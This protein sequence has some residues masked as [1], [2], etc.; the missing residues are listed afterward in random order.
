MRYRIS[1]ISTQHSGNVHIQEYSCLS[2]TTS[3][4][5]PA[6]SLSVDVTIE[7]LEPGQDMLR[8]LSDFED[9]L[10]GSEKIHP[11]APS[12]EELLRLHAPEFLL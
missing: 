8:S 4:P 3:L 1:S 11:D 2:G 9:F 5:S 7:I 12:Y 6:P 10:S